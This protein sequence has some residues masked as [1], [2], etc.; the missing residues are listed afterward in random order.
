MTDTNQT[1]VKS[2]HDGKLLAVC[3]GLRVGPCFTKHGGKKKS[4]LTEPVMR[5]QPGYS[6]S[7]DG[8]HAG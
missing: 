2:D 3:R 7:D 6:S 8:A 4:F 1:Q 5:N